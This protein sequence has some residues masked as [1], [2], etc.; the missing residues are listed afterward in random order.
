MEHAVVLNRDFGVRIS[1]VEVIDITVDGTNPVI[2]HRH[3][4]TVLH[5]A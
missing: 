3:G 5:N 2:N 1:Q 4:Q